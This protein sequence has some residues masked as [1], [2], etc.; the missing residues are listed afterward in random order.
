VFYL[1]A[2][3]AIEMV[4]MALIETQDEDNDEIDVETQR[5]IVNKDDEDDQ[6]RKQGI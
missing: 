2:N 6:G 4:E 5:Q 1:A 3:S